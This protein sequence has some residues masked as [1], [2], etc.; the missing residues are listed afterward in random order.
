MAQCKWCGKSGFLFPVNQH[1]IC[2]NCETV[3]NMEIQ[4]RIR[5]L[6]DSLKIVGETKNI[7]T[8]IS[9]VDL[10]IQHS[11]ALMK[12]EKKGIPTTDRPPSKSPPSEIFNAFQSKRDTLIVEKLDAEYISLIKSLE[13]PSV[14]AKKKVNDL[15]KLLLKSM[16]IK[17]KLKNSA[18][19]S[20]LENK[21]KRQI[22]NIQ[23]NSLLEEAQKAEFKNN[24]KSA[25]SKYYEALYFLE[26]DIVDDSLQNE[27][28][29]KLKTKIIE[30]GGELKV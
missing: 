4:S 1:G 11:E 7:D 30:L 15:N 29:S 2:S 17:P 5:I 19:I 14:S 3:I 27:Q 9:R 28:I 13:L 16:E 21:I 22:N 26:H 6:F 8:F 10:I 25:L 20:N 24:K 18:I 23:F 12:Y